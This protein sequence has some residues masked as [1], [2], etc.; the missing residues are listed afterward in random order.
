MIVNIIVN[1][2]R[3]N[4]MAKFLKYK[5]LH[6]AMNNNINRIFKA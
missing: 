3:I 2:L 6:S 4:G 1:K 5:M